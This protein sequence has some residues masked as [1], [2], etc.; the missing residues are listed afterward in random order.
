MYYVLEYIATDGVQ[1]YTSSPR[2]FPSGS[3]LSASIEVH[4]DWAY[5]FS[6]YAINAAGNSAKTYATA[7]V[8]VPPLAA[9]SG[10]TFGD[11]AF[12]KDGSV[13]YADFSLSWFADMT[14]VR[15]TKSKL[16]FSDD[17]QTWQPLSTVGDILLH[18]VGYQLYASTSVHMRAGETFYIR[19][20]VGNDAGWSP[21]GESRSILT[22]VP[23]TAPA[24]LRSSLPQVDRLQTVALSWDAATDFS[25]DPQDT[26]N[27]QVFPSPTLSLPSSPLIVL[28][29]A[30]YIYR[31]F[32]C[33]RMG[34]PY[35]CLFL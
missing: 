3:A 9:P 8:S 2:V 30:S 35:T 17:Q 5:T 27:Y 4:S 6:V 13:N 32:H 24:S 18:T 14:D 26:I 22:L 1:V 33:A 16:E 23:P 12:S 10:V 28:L 20:F 15:S 21:F 11:L 7:S 34:H 25:N 31:T 19:A 29:V